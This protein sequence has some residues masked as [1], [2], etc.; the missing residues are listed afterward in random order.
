MDAKRG[1][2]KLKEIESDGALASISEV[3]AAKVMVSRRRSTRPPQ[4][5]TAPAAAPEAVVETSTQQQQQSPE[6]KGMPPDQVAR[7]VQRLSASQDRLAK[8]TRI[9]KAIADFH[10]EITSCPE[11]PDATDKLATAHR[12]AP[13][14]GDGDTLAVINSLRTYMRVQRGF[15]EDYEK[16]LKISLKT[17]TV[18]QKL[19]ETH[20]RDELNRLQK[21]HEALKLERE[22]IIVQ[23]E[24][25]E[26]GRALLVQEGLDAVE[27]ERAVIEQL[28]AE[29]AATNIELGKAQE[30]AQALAKALD[31]KTTDA[32]TLTYE[33]ATLKHTVHEL[34]FGMNRRRSSTGLSTTSV[35]QSTSPRKTSAAIV[36]ASELRQAH[37]KISQLETELA[38]SRDTITDL[39]QRVQSLKTSLHSSVVN[40]AQKEA[41]RLRDREQ[42]KDEQIAELETALLKT[43]SRLHEKDSRLAALKTEYDKIF[44][45]L[46]KE[47]QQKALGNSPPK[48]S[49]EDANR[50]ANENVYVT[51]YYKTRHEHQAQEI[52]TLRK[53]IKK[54]LSLEHKQYFDQHQRAKEHARLE[55]NYDDLKRQLQETVAKAATDQKIA[56]AAH[57]T[58][59]PSSAFLCDDL[60]KLLAR[61]EFLEA[62][63]RDHFNDMRMTT[64]NVTMDTPPPALLRSASTSSVLSAIKTR[65]KSAGAI[66]PKGI[67]T[68][69]QSFRVGALL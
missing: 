7:L 34:E 53:Q 56:E 35:Q 61:H 29:L 40:K 16:T 57:T 4:S 49:N 18:A 60:N 43:K 31:E 27:R 3:V 63:Y 52:L 38:T 21:A 51:E 62:F 67:G 14:T 26:Q 58:R 32:N 64:V 47:N 5:K 25:T 13:P 44:T 41:Q 42:H 12:R 54:L 37:M 59:L 55:Q 48:V 9:E 15:K 46:Q 65:P 69:R 28:R 39:K 20:A 8:L 17:A 24:Q 36:G 45:A 1:K 11:D 66:K 19:E 10:D 68:T 6:E 33:V 30:R 2:S 23:M 50:I 22:V